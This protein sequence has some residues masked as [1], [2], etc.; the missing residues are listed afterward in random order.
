[1]A[2]G[3]SIASAA[4]AP[5]RQ[6]AV[7]SG[8][9]RRSQAGAA[10]RIESLRRDGAA[11]NSAGLFVDAEARWSKA[12]L[13]L[14]GQVPEPAVLVEVLGGLAVSYRGAGRLARSREV[15]GAALRLLAPGSV[16]DDAQIWRLERGI[17]QSYAAEGSSTLAIASHR[18]ALAAAA[19]HPDRLRENAIRSQMDL[20]VVLIGADEGSS[21]TSSAEEALQLA[22]EQ[23]ARDGVTHD[24]ILNLAAT[25]VK[26]GRWEAAQKLLEQERGV[27]RIWRP[28]YAEP[29]NAPLDEAVLRP[30]AYGTIVGSGKVGVRLSDAWAYCAYKFGSAAEASG[31]TARL[32]TVVGRDG[33][34]SEVVLTAFG[35]SEPAADC[36]VLEAAAAK[37]PPP[38]GDGA[39]VVFATETFP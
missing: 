14:H 18:Q 9:A 32:S 11:Y 26:V 27:L 5:A 2:W 4:C 25:Y 36:M 8:P 1:M 21:A 28:R 31:R 38:E 35:L 17:G 7:A 22:R 29:E 13:L 6:N 37:F 30:R 39:V 15:A 20:S 23:G 33:R 3:A 12:L 34:I 24:A 19:R 16:S 10:E